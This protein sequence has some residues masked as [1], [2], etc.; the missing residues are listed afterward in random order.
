MTISHL[1]KFER[2]D[3]KQSTYQNP[4]S[5]KMN[6]KKYCLTRTNVSE[7]VASIRRRCGRIR[8]CSGRSYNNMKLIYN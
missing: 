8:R 2:L 7:A 5:R 1:N 3:K 4:L 6:S